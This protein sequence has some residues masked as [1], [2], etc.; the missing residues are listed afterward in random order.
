ME[1]PEARDRRGWLGRAFRVRPSQRSLAAS[2]IGRSRRDLLLLLAPGSLL[3]VLFVV[4]PIA[5]TVYEAFFSV[6]PG[7]QQTWVGLEWFRQA[8]FG[9]PVFLRAMVNTV[10]WAT[11]SVFVDIGLAFFLAL[12]LRSR[13]KGWRFFRTAWFVPILLSPVLVGLVWR[14][15]LTY[16]GGLLNG[17]LD[18]IGLRALEQDW[19]GGPLALFWLFNMATWST[20]GLYMVLMLAALED[21]PQDL[22]DAARVDGANWWQEVR[23]VFLP[24]LR[25]VIVTLVILTFIYKMRVFDLVWVTTQGGPY[26]LTQTVVTWVMQRAFYFQGAFDF[27]YPA[28]MSAIWLLV[29]ALGVALIRWLGGH[30]EYEY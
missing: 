21:F 12:A 1:S 8:L 30:E 22:I 7:G 19:L 9:D 28:A 10:M 4:Y 3:F 2:H 24:L 17:I 20:V 23:Y 6:R 18:G 15:M 27:G 5:A 11:W 29:M 26:N 13:I 14:S 25:P 16:Q